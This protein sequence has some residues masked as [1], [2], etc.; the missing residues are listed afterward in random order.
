MDPVGLAE[1]ACRTRRW[2]KVATE[3]DAHGKTD[4]T[5]DVDTET[6][7][8]TMGQQSQSPEG[9]NGASP[10][11]ILRLGRCWVMTKGIMRRHLVFGVSKT[12]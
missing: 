9:N 6:R 5:G 3:V 1:M 2:G 7:S 8:D 4:A 10:V 12:C 11:G